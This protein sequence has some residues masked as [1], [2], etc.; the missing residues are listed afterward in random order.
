MHLRIDRNASEPLVQQIVAGVSGWIRGNRVRAGTRIPS[1]RQLARENQAQPVQRDRGLRPPGRP[2]DAG[3]AARLGVLRRRGARRHY[4]PRQRMARRRGKRMGP[5][6]RQLDETQARL[7]LDSGQLAGSRGTQLRDPPGRPQ[8]TRR[9]VRLQH[10]AGP[11]GAAPAHPETPAADRYPCRP[12]ADPHH[13]RRQP[14]PRPVGTHAAQAGRRGGGGEPRLLQPVQPAEVP[15]GEDARRAAHPPRPGHRRAGDDP[16][17]AQAEV[18][19][20]QQHVPQ[21]HRHQPQPLSGPP[22]AA[23]GRAA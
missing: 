14:C 8:R 12:G 4:R 11:A 15:R 20:H 23:T 16:P 18:P 19:F 7:R 6:Q 2:G 10:S 1:I 21:P 22:R 5:V 3:I 17:R 9:A 13:H